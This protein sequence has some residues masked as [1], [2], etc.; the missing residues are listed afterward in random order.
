MESQTPQ[1][2]Y[3]LPANFDY[4][5]EWPMRDYYDDGPI[6]ID[7]YI[8]EYKT[9][10][11]V[12]WWRLKQMLERWPAMRKSWEAFIIDYNVCLATLRSEEDNDDITF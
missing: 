4:D 7:D 5:T 10:E 9:F 8:V 1:L 11:Q 2:D 12:S 6:T 3:N